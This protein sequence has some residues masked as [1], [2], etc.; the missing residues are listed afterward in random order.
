MFRILGAVL[1]L[2]ILIIGAPIILIR[3][4]IGLIITLPVFIVTAFALLVGY[5]TGKK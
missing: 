5:I 1:N 2:I 4:A 3:A